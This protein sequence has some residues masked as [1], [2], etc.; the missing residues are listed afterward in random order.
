MDQNNLRN[1]VYKYCRYQKVIAKEIGCDSVYLNL[2]LKGK[3]EIGK[4]KL[5]LINTWIDKQRGE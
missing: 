1:E 3:V 4:N 5:I 2:W